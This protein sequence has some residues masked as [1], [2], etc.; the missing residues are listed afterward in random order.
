[1]IYRAFL[2]DK[3]GK[4]IIN[5]GKKLSGI[6][7]ISGSKNAA[8]PILCATVINGGINVINNCPNIS[9]ID[10]MCSLLNDIGC[11]VVRNGHT[12]T[13]DSSCADG[14][15]LS[16]E[17]VKKIRSSVTL[18]G[19]MAGRFGS[20][21]TYKPGGCTIG[22]RPVDIHIEAL[23]KLGAVVRENNETLEIKA[24]KLT[25]SVINLPFPS[26]G[27]TENIMMA[28]VFANGTTAI[29]NAAREPEIVC[30]QS[31]LC[32]I[33]VKIYGAETG[34][35]IIEGCKKFND[36]NFDIIYDRIE[37]GT[38]LTSVAMCKGELFLKNA[39][40]KEMLSTIKCLSAMGCKIYVCDEGI[41]ISSNKR[42]KNIECLRTG[43]Y[44]YF[45]T[46]MQPQITSLLT[47]SK[48][49]SIIVETVFEKRMEYTKEIKKFSAQLS[50]SDRV[51]IV[52]GVKYVTG[53]QVYAKDL[54]AGAALINMAL[55][56]KGQSTVWGSQYVE[57][58]YENIEK[59]LVKV[60]ADIKID[61]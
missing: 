25:S 18:M 37:S 56:A 51:C 36:T 8:L 44:P 23:K 40:W 32:S 49:T 26:V 12:I 11:S 29:V 17:T 22:A 19:A 50:A 5:G 34:T 10:D 31:F 46:D 38:F 60:G 20:F 48:G 14:L 45:P 21:V 6:I 33:G 41:Y 57:R 52:N 61:K 58:G 39:P 55:C 15:N 2:G 35:I 27:A 24:D 7:D 42:L 13:V 28:A 1:M 30:L 9:D 16:Y 43:V 47:L 53:A 3:M 4:Y 59:K 54:R